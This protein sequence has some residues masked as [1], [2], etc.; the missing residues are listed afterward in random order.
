MTPTPSSPAP[1]SAMPLAGRLRTLVVPGIAASIALAILVVLGTWQLSRLAWKNGLVAQVEQRTRAPAIPLPSRDAWP[2]MSPARDDYRRVT[3]TGRFRHDAEAYL[4]H[5]A[6]DSRQADATRPRGQG[7]FVLTP[8]VTAD[9]DTVIVNRGFVP[10]D[11]RDPATRAAGQVDGVVS[12]T[13]LIRYPEERGALAAPD[14]P[15]RR[16]FYTRDLAGIGRTLG[17]EAAATAPFS[18]DAD[19]TPVPG[20]LPVGGETRLVFTNRHFEYALTWF[21]LALTLVGVFGAYAFQR[22]RGR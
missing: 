5:V 21:G 12:V 15:A 20:G 4:Y 2:R 14:D 7:F 16:T 22:L 18:V 11:R 1:G 17:L 19:A 13:G 9:G 6:G 10:T 3:V 8:L